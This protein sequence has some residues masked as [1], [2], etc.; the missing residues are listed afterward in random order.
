MHP[1]SCWAFCLLY[2]SVLI[3][4]WGFWLTLQDKP[5]NH[6]AD[7]PSAPLRH[8]LFILIDISRGS[9]MLC[10][11]HHAS[12]IMHCISPRSSPTGQATENC[13]GN[14]SFEPRPPSFYVLMLQR[15]TER[16]NFLGLNTNNSDHSACFLNTFE[17]NSPP[18]QRPSGVSELLVVPRRFR[19]CPLASLQAR[20]VPVL[21][22]DFRAKERPCLERLIACL[23]STDDSFI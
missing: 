18:G 6:S 21:V 5:T 14:P 11:D 13:V 23:P 7:I 12:C 22:Q 20:I 10:T 17:F 15:D 8:G 4:F 1:H 3:H 19:C 16:E 9:S 2:V